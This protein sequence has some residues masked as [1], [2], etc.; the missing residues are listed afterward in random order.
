MLKLLN[1]RNILI[2]LVVLATVLISITIEEKFVEKT[3]VSGRIE[4]DLKT[5]ILK[6]K[7]DNS[8]LFKKLKIDNNRFL[9]SLNKVETSFYSSTNRSTIKNDTIYI[10]NNKYFI[11]YDP[12]LKIVDKNNNIVFSLNYRYDDFFFIDNKLYTLNTVYNRKGK[13]E[14]LYKIVQLDNELIFSDLYLSFFLIMISLY[15]FSLLSYHFFSL[16]NL[17]YQNRT[18]LIQYDFFSLFTFNRLMSKN[19]TQK[20]YFV[21]KKD[22]NSTPENSKLLKV[23][24]RFY[25]VISIY[26]QINWS[27]SDIINNL[28]SF[29]GEKNDKLIELLTELENKKIDDKEKLL[30]SSMRKKSINEIKKNIDIIK[31]ISKIDISGFEQNNIIEFLR[32]IIEEYPVHKI[33]FNIKLKKEIGL[34]IDR[35]LFRTALKNIIDNAVEYT[36]NHTSKKDVNIHTADLFP[37]L[38]KLEY[39]L[40]NTGLLPL[41]VG[42]S[43]KQKSLVRIT[44]LSVKKS[45]IKIIIE[46]QIKDKI[47][48]EKIGTLGYTTKETGTGIGILLSK[49]I[50]EKHKGSLECSLKN[51]TF[52]V[53][54]IL[55]VN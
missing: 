14:L 40:F 42:T 19:K 48:I 23:I 12:S 36:S 27:R 28:S 46:N 8:K 39:C 18:Y 22:I 10:F 17:F 2:L 41:A 38:N 9:Y 49:R 43:E 11:N 6:Y 51:D 33:N 55:P 53:E 50:I 37:A 7:I 34:Y 31:G 47:D 25:I 54:I 4:K 24:N 1:I 44:L 26:E 52:I 30:I 16:P 21:Y 20:S 35:D 29:I 13:T 3:V 5:D 15:L 32:S 45:E